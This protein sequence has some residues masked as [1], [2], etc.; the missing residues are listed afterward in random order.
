MLYVILWSD[1]LRVIHLMRFYRF[2]NLW[3]CENLQK[4]FF[5]KKKE[6]ERERERK[7]ERERER[8]RVKRVKEVKRLRERW[9]D[10]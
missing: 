8:E 3:I 9:I 2:M 4:V 7:R 6:R 5:K 10:E 1:D